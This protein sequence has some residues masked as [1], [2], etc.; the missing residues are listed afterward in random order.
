MASSTAKKVVVRRF[1]RET[2][3]GF[4][5]PYTYLQHQAI[6]VLRPD[7]ALALLPYTEVKSVSFVK[8]FEGAQETGR[9]FM[10]RPKLEGLWVRM[11][12]QDGEVMD[13]I[14][15]NNLLTWDIAGFTVTPPEPD[16]NSQK[17]FVPRQALRGIQILGVVGSPLRTKKKK[18]PAAD[19]PSLF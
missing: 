2:L 6:E 14:L 15:P 4:V 19:Q 8:D 7:G 12:F 9:I 16:G 3:S 13:G 11:V 1:D 10:T 18:A 17:I 5:N